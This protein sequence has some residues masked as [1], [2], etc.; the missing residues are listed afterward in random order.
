M[1]S[2][3]KV[4]HLKGEVGFCCS[5]LLLGEQI[6]DG[7]NGSAAAVFTKDN[8]LN[9]VVSSVPAGLTRDEWLAALPRAMVAGFV[10]TD[11]DWRSK[12][13]PDGNLRGTFGV[14]IYL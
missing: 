4:F 2:W 3:K 14:I 12:G 6:L 8:L 7:H 9:N 1:W 10:K 11:K 5:D 13:T